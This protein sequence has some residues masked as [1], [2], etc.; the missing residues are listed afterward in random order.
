MSLP[1]CARN[2]TLRDLEAILRH[3][4]AAKLDVVAPATAI[5]SERGAIV[6]SGVTP[7]L[8]ERG[9]TT[10][11][12]RYVPTAAADG[13]IAAKLGIS[14][15][16]LRRLRAERVDLFDANVN[17]WLHGHA[18][19]PPDPRSF[20]LRLFRRDDGD[21][22]L[23]A[24][25]SDSYG[26]ID[27]LDVLTAVLDGIR[28]ADVDVE[29][30]A[31]DL[32]ESAMHCKV[33]S[34]GVA[35]LAPAL[36]AGYRNP[37]SDPTLDAERR[38]IVTDLDD[39]RRA[40]QAE[41]QGYDEEPVVFAGFRFSN[42]EIGDGSVTLKPELFVRVCSN[43][44]TLPALAVRKVHMSGRM[45]A[46]TVT[47]SRDTQNKHLA[48]IASQARDA[49]RHWL[50]PEFLAEQVD[51]VEQT[52]ATPVTQPESTVKVVAKRLGFTDAERE[53]VLRHFIAGGQLTTGGLAHAITSFSQTVA[54]PDRADALDDLALTAMTSAHRPR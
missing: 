18:D 50:S 5:R 43:G 44:L 23:R 20:L 13:T 19:N 29:V 34:P 38:R 31:C 54:D 4:H 28:Q 24:M 41:G 47:W 30:R 7:L 14:L 17:G 42:S 16:Y 51:H 49:V 2:A 10:V 39:G 8:D 21:G 48:V 52:A 25:L 27:N 1:T 12:G 33:Y 11:D 53:G 6:L 40:A 37:F 9:V 35:R 36:L 45:E 3:Q 26:I 46:G 15:R 22:V 32:S